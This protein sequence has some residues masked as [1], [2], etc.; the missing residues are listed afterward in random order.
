MK[1]VD[2]NGA[3]GSRDYFRQ[4][5]M[6][7]RSHRL[8]IEARITGYEKEVSRFEAM[9][10]ELKVTPP[11]PEGE[12]VVKLESK[13]DVRAQLKVS[14]LVNEA[15]FPLYDIRAKDIQSPVAITYKAN[16]TQ[17]SGEDWENVKLTVSSADPNSTGSRP[18]VKPWILGF[19]NGIEGGLQGRVMGIQ[20]TGPSMISGQVIGSDGK[21]LPER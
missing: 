1:G 12:I 6:D 9:K 5:M 18:E 17:Q 4:R 14:Y 2:I 3:E 8:E 10:S 20:S 21:P 16:I 7:I 15:S 19:N 13:S 11:C